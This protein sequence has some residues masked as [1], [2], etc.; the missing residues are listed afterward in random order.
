MDPLTQ[1]LP[2]RDDSTIPC[3]THS[4]CMLPVM[5]HSGIDGPSYPAAARD[6][7]TIPCDTHSPCMLPVMRHSG[8]DGPSYPAAARQG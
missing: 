3:D 1:L 6:D 5:R 8:M 4:P 7:S 2:G